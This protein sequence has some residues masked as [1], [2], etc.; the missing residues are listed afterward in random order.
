MKVNVYTQILLTVIAVCLTI[1]VWQQLHLI[2]PAQAS[3]SGMPIDVNIKSVNGQYIYNSIPVKI[4][5]Q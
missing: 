3:T 2:T 1:Q 5:N 4:Q